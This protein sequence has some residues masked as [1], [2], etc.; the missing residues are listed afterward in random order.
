VQF[1]HRFDAPSIRDLQLAA[2]GVKWTKHPGALG[3]FVA[4]MDFGPAPVITEALHKAVDAGIFG[5]LP[6]PWVERMKV[7][8][9]DWSKRRYGWEIDPDFVHQMPDVISVMMVAIEYFSAPQSAVVVPTPAYMPFLSVPPQLGREVIQ[10]P[11]IQDGQTYRFDLDGLAQAFAKGGG[12]LIL[13]NPSNPL[14]VSFNEEELRGVSEVVEAAGARVFADEIHAPMIYGGRRHVPYA[15]ISDI[16]ANH[17]ITGVSASKGWN[18]P[19]LKCA[20]AIVTNHADQAK[21]ETLPTKATRGTANLGVVAHTVAYEEGEPW[22]DEVLAY[23]QSACQYFVDELAIHAPAAKMRVPDATYIGWIDLRDCGLGDA[24]A[25]ALAEKVNLYLNEGTDLGDG[26]EGFVR[27]AMA[28]PRP[29]LG[30]IARRI[31]MATR[32]ESL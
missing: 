28:T 21:W 15:S 9:A 6:A 20:Q 3:A 25:A 12:L 32:N 2:A 27:I 30:E 5:Y 13:C 26:L 14:G 11:M 23:L 29:V 8:T 31:G 17:S 22:L 7:A 18:L 24:P 1:D 4:E 19:G 16:A 10:V